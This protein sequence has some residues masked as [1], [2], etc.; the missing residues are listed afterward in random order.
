MAIALDLNCIMLNIAFLLVLV[1][2]IDDMYMPMEKKRFEWSV[3]E[4]MKKKGEGKKI[5]MAHT[6]MA[7]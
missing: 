2:A 7:E 6:K 3:C 4:K 1:A 5:G